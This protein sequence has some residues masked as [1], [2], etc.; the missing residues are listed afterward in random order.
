[1]NNLLNYIMHPS[2]IKSESQS[3]D[4]FDKFQQ[5]PISEIEDQ[6][7]ILDQLTSHLFSIYQINPQ[8]ASSD[9]Q[10]SQHLINQ[11]SSLIHNFHFQ[12]SKINSTSSKLEFPIFFYRFIKTYVKSLR[13]IPLTNDISIKIYAS[14]APLLCIYL[15]KVKNNDTP[16]SISLSDFILLL[17]LNEEPIDL[18]I[19]FLSDF[20]KFELY[21]EKV[22]SMFS[23]IFSPETVSQA[24]VEKYRSVL[25]SLR[26]LQQSLLPRPSQSSDY[27]A[28]LSLIEDIKLAMTSFCEK[29]ISREASSILFLLSEIE[30]NLNYVRLIYLSKEHLKTVISIAS[31]E[32]FDVNDIIVDKFNKRIAENIRQ[33]YL[34]QI[35]ALVS[36]NENYSTFSEKINEIFKPLTLQHENNDPFDMS[37]DH[38]KVRAFL[39]SLPNYYDTS[40]IKEMS[41]SF[42]TLKLIDDVFPLN[43]YDDVFQLYMAF[44]R[45]ADDFIKEGKLHQDLMKNLLIAES[46]IILKTFSNEDKNHINTPIIV[47]IQKVL[48][49]LKNISAQPNVDVILLFLKHVLKIVKLFFKEIQDDKCIQEMKT[50]LAAHLPSFEVLEPIFGINQKIFDLFSFIKQYNFLQ[51]HKYVAKTSDEILEM[52]EK[53]ENCE[54]CLI[55]KQRQL[56]ELILR[57]IDL[58]LSFKDL[59]G[60]YAK[61]IELIG[62]CSE[63]PLDHFHFEHDLFNISDSI[64]CLFCSENGSFEYDSSFFL[65]WITFLFTMLD[66]TND[67]IE[68]EQFI[69]FLPFYDFSNIFTT[70]LF[71]FTIAKAVAHESSKISDLIESFRSYAL[72]II[73]NADFK[74][75]NLRSYTN[76]IKELTKSKLPQCYRRIE[77]CISVIEPHIIIIAPIICLRNALDKHFASCNF[78]CKPMIHFNYVLSIYRVLKN[79]ISIDSLNQEYKDIYNELIEEFHPIFESQ[80]KSHK[81]FGQ[82]E[83]LDQFII[84]FLSKVKKLIHSFDI[85]LFIEIGLEYV[86]SISDIFFNESEQELSSKTLSYLLSLK[87]QVEDLTHKQT[88]FEKLQSVSLILYTLW[89]IRQQPEESIDLYNQF[90]EITNFAF[91]NYNLMEV[92]IVVQ[93]ILCQKLG[94]GPIYDSDKE[95]SGSHDEFN[96]ILQYDN[97]SSISNTIQPLG[98]QM[99][100]LKSC[101]DVSGLSEMPHSKKIQSLL[102]DFRVAFETFHKTIDPFLSE[103]SE[104]FELINEIQQI[105]ETLSE[106][107]EKWK[108]LIEE[109]ETSYKNIRH[110]CIELRNENEADLLRLKQLSL[111]V[112]S[113]RKKIDEILSQIKDKE[114]EFKAQNEKL[115]PTMKQKQKQEF[116]ETIHALRNLVQTTKVDPDEISSLTKQLEIMNEKN[117]KLRNEIQRLD[118]QHMNTQEDEIELLIATDM[119]D[120][121]FSRSLIQPDNGE[122]ENESLK[123]QIRETEQSIE[124][125]N[126][127][128]KKMQNQKQNFV[129]SVSDLSGDEIIS[130][131]DLAFL[132][133]LHSS[134]AST[135]PNSS[136]QIED[137]KDFRQKTMERIQNM[138]KEKK[139]LMEERNQLMKNINK[140]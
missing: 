106:Q 88:Y 54:I 102:N 69:E 103:E 138:I 31:K 130:S 33:V 70:S 51:N 83:Q 39:T 99:C 105:T 91:L 37:L 100:E 124:R 19:Q 112:I 16:L 27:T 23:S 24:M 82:Y 115:P 4:Q 49:I 64:Y 9:F 114:N 90:L 61:L 71:T 125:I 1:M 86:Y 111:G 81:F 128:R 46:E 110:S 3:K 43:Y 120:L 13:L 126:K 34:K 30:L 63:N 53:E 62:G 57:Q 79:M 129:D 74:S 67:A 95:F 80:L 65:K 104:E 55:E 32:A 93:H 7:F 52:C 58:L 135:M 122:I 134:R 136:V 5:N 78:N 87:L 47:T 76:K 36:C 12:E 42:P 10:H 109:K 133:F 140:Q 108:N 14:F 45:E 26:S 66:P 18:I 44:A 139:Q 85:S 127:Q 56:L 29:N 73:L 11:I 48:S 41:K 137:F 50:Y 123:A 119:Q 72:D 96:T 6:S 94:F 89:N 21:I 131:P 121:N 2:L 117:T 22:I 116:S 84:P 77:R 107:R 118:T 8:F 92:V 35:K 20:H 28:S 40:L 97:F 101:I 132:K 17:T 75:L 15:Q 98:E 60:E 59:P 113:Q 25:E 68:A 38:D